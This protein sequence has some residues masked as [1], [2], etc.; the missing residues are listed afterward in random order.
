MHPVLQLAVV[1]LKKQVLCLPIFLYHNAEVCNLRLK[2]LGLAKKT[3]M[4]SVRRNSV[5][6]MDE[7][8]IYISE[9]PI[10]KKFQHAN[11]R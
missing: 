7:P 11:F 4:S 3:E 6:L 5:D 1:L 8:I 2:I 10:K 9:R